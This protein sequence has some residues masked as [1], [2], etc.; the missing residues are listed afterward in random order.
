MT[1]LNKAVAQIRP[2]TSGRISLYAIPLS[3]DELCDQRGMIAEEKKILV[4]KKGENKVF[5]PLGYNINYDSLNAM[6][7]LL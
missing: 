3:W 4:V 7:S 1:F 6:R 5:L 2:A